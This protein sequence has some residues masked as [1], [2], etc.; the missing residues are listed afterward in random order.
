[1]NI[2]AITHAAQSSGGILYLMVV[3]LFVALTVALERSWYLARVI[4]GGKRLLGTLEPLPS[5]PDE[6]LGELAQTY[7]HLPFG[8][9]LETA[10]SHNSAH[11]FDRLDDRLEESM[12]RSAQHTD[13]LFWLLDTIITLAPLLGLLGTII[14]MFNAFQVLSNPGNAPTQITGGVAE[15]LL[16]TAS[17]LF[18]AMI[19]LV[20]F[21]GL[22]IRVRHV[23]QQMDMLKTMLVN[24][25]HTHRHQQLHGIPTPA[26]SANV[27]H[28]AKHRLNEGT[29]G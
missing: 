19:G 10:A 12:M 5:L 4:H 13:R 22:N 11:P 27:L 25:M 2:E 24:R 9:M 26:Q 15:A 8:R 21:N 3:L 1:M 23:L 7:H 18:V 20:F 6:Q 17:G 16:A 14:G 29:H 28:V